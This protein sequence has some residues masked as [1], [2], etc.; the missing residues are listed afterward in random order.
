[1]KVKG[2]NKQ[3]SD[4]SKRPS[5]PSNKP[6]IEKVINLVEVEALRDR[7]ELIADQKNVHVPESYE[8][9]DYEETV[10]V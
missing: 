9:L 2:K 3:V 8:I 4:K 1:M 10:M 6:S 5:K 7:A